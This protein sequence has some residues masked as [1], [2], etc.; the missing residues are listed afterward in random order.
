MNNITPSL[1]VCKIDDVSINAEAFDNLP[2]VRQCRI[3]QAIKPEKAAQLYVSSLLL[4]YVLNQY[5]KKLDD[6]KV[7]ES[8]KPYLEDNFQ[9]N[10]SHSGQY[11]VIAVSENV[12]GVDVQEKKRISS[13]AAKLFLNED[14]LNSDLQNDY[15]YSYI[16][17]RKEAFLKCLGVGWNGKRAA[18]ASVL[19]NEIEFEENQYFLTDYLI[20]DNYFLSL[21][22]KNNHEAF[23]VKEVSKHELEI[24]YRSGK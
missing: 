10:V 18:K 4:G 13:A 23:V 22:E 3:K 16:W 15:Y 5:G 14:A 1:Y 7:T 12:V 19:K 9:F 6:V 8:G 21:C 24:F 11:A 20:S 2:T 17:C